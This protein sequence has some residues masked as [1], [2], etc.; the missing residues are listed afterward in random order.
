MTAKTTEAGPQ[1]A[2]REPLTRERILQAALR[3]MDE[4]GLEAVTMRRVGRELG[5]EAMS[6]YNHVEDKEAILDGVCE[7]ILAEFELPETIEAD[8]WGP[9]LRTLGRSFRQLLKA[10]PNV[11]TLLAQH[12]HPVM[13]P[14]AWRPLEALLGTLRR[15]GMTVEETA[16]AQSLL[17]AFVIGFVMH[18]TQGT[19]HPGG[20]GPGPDHETMGRLLGSYGLVNLAELFPRLKDCDFDADFE[21][22]M[23]VIGGGLW[24]RLNPE[25]PP[26]SPRR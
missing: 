24:T 8:D 18:E 15:A 11:I 12:R 17:I 23:D 1:E 16:R 21:Y 7:T 25:P 2:H 6:L 10:H 22:G 5:V 26:V 13:A 9:A 20:E 14:E 3:I 19:F 4:E